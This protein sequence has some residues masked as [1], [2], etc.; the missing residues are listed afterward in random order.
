M[1]RSLHP[2]LTYSFIERYI[3]EANEQ[4]MVTTH[5]D[6]I[7]EWK[8][9]RRDE[10]WFVEKNEQGISKLFSLEAYKVR[11]DKNIW[12]AYW[13]GRYGGVPVLSRRQ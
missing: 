3:Q 10:V 12:A 2:N 5:E 6:R 11:F 1:D 4:L 7:L 13:E 9:L 8:L